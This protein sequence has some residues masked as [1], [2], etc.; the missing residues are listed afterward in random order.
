MI[1]YIKEK[2]LQNISKV[3][4]TLKPGYYEDVLL[5]VR[6]RNANLPPR[7]TLGY[8]HVKYR[9][10]LKAPLN[11]PLIFYGKLAIILGIK[12]GVSLGTVN[13]P[14]KDNSGDTPV[15]TYCKARLDRP[16]DGSRSAGEGLLRITVFPFSRHNQIK[17]NTFS[18]IF[19]LVISS[20]SINEKVL[21]ISVHH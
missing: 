4:N 12:P 17:W 9:I 8:D 5:L 6:E 3:C 16:N 2:N 15:V 20:D 13:Q 18:Y 1:I 21:M 10:F 7:V 14:R 19:Y 11:T